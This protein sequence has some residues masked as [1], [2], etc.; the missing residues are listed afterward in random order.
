MSTESHKVSVIVP[1]YNHGQFLEECLNSVLAQTHS[2][3]ECIVVDNGSTDNT[4]EV[5][6]RFTSKDSRFKYLFTPQKGVS[7]ARNLG[8]KNSSGVYILPL[9]A[10]DSIHPKFV[11]KTLAL[12]TNNPNAKLVYSNARLFGNSSGDWKLPE[13]SFRN[14]LIENSIFCTSLYKRTDYDKT[15]GYNESM[16]EGFEDWDFWILL[17]KSGGDVLKVEEVLFNY[18]IRNQ[19]RNNSLDPKKQLALRKQI[20]ENHKELYQK[21]FSIPD[22]LYENYT[23][24]NSLQKVQK[25]K[26][27]FFGRFIFSPLRTLKRMF[28]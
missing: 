13:Y 21:H 12:M 4:S 22:L 27:L 14:L 24:N 15:S 8:I 3:W 10:D 6:A 5:S 19:S 20:F 23:L 25:S 7:F 16:L 11:E 28:S 2:D 18:R 17:L 26:E 9:D 1:C